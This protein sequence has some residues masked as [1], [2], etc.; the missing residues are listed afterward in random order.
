MRED[1]VPKDKFI[2]TTFPH[3][4][5]VIIPCESGFVW[6]QQTDGVM[7]HQVYTE[8]VFIPLGWPYKWEQDWTVRRDLLE[9]ISQMNYQYKDV[10]SLW[11]EVK[12]RMHF[13]F[14]EVDAPEGQHR[15]IEGYQ[16]I[17]FTKFEPG[18]GHGKWVKQLIGKVVVLIYPNSD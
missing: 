4:W 13:D 7:C 12:E 8:G 17:K 5:G 10:S 16:W 6:Q 3:N 18:W 1:Q 15:S 2:T 9:E 11:K 14:E